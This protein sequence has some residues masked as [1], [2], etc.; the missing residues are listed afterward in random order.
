MFR[1]DD[2]E[3][4]LALPRDGFRVAVSTRF[5]EADFEGYLFGNKYGLP[6]PTDMYQAIVVSET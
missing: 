2:L 5:Q 6:K 3:A 1:N 4:G